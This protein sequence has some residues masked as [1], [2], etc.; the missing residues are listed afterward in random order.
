MPTKI[1]G[2]RFE[3]GQ[4]ACPVACKYCFITEHDARRELWNTNPIAGVNRAS[5]FINVTPWI[6]DSREEQERFFRFPFEILEGDFVGFTAV[7]DPFWPKLDRFLWHFLETVSPIAKLVTCVTKWPIKRK[8]MRRLAR[9]ENFCLIVGITGNRP[10]VEK[11]TVHQHLDTLRLA[12]EEGVRALPISHPY[13][14]ELSDLSFLPE[15]SK[16]GYN[17]FDVKG[18]RYC[19]TQMASWIPERSRRHYLGRETEE[20]LP[21]DGWRKLV[22]DSGFSLLSPRQWYLREGLLRSPHLLREDAVA[23]VEKVLE[24]ANVVSSADRNAVY[25]AAIERRL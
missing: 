13:I 23:R 25:E 7:T 1:S 4:P 17:E 10:P 5:T 19:D 15:L 22:T 16:L 18:L 11:V 20:V 6:A 2:Q 8:V 21:E 14:A 12:K 3:A 24:I 9:I